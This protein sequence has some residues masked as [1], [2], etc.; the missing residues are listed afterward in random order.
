MAH[1]KQSETV[2]GE[3]ELAVTMP[4]RWQL[5]PSDS[6]CRWLYRNAEQHKEQ[7]S[8][9][10][11]EAGG[12]AGEEAATLRRIVARHRRGMELH[13]GSVSDLT[14]S[15]PDYSERFGLPVVEYWGESPTAGHR[16]HVFLICPPRTVWALV[17]DVFRMDSEQSDAHAAA[18]FENVALR[19]G[20]F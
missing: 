1:W 9:T 17:H 20:R 5:R 8:L 4:G 2:F 18:V 15:E 7:I 11:E 16:F 3:Y 12:V 6:P 10:R 14:L 19:L 13:L